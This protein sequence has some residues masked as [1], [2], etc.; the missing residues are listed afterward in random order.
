MPNILETI[1]LYFQDPSANSDKFY[2]IAI[3]QSGGKH[4]VPFTYGRRGT[5]GQSGYKVQDVSYEEAKKAYNKVIGEKTGK[6]YHEGEGM[7]PHAGIPATAPAEE[8][9]IG[10]RRIKWEGETPTLLPQLLNEIQEEEIEKYIN[11]PAY[12]AQEKH[13]GKRRMLKYQSG[14]TEGLNKKGKVVGYPAVFEGACKSTAELNGLQEFIMDGEEVGEVFHAFDLLSLNNEDLRNKVYG[15]RYDKLC[16]LSCWKAWTGKSVQNNSIKIVETA[17]TTKGKRDLYNRLKETKKEGI[18]FKLLSGVH[19]VGYSPDQC[20]F[21][22]T[23]TAS[24]IVTGHNKKN[25]ISIGV[26]NENK[27]IPIGNVTMIGHDKSKNPVGSVCECRYLYFFPGGSLYQPVYLGPRD[28]M[29]KED[30]QL[31]KL[32]CKAKE[33]DVE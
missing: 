13:D 9:F 1:T 32:K 31:S 33:E 7:S 3:E 14:K 5:S 17:F 18:I 29:D 11:D 15:I 2:T 26:M 24:V 19:K 10:K 6:G 30:C 20:K 12:C 25:S 28:D 23:S 22:F 8:S 16:R 27:L 21:K 4:S